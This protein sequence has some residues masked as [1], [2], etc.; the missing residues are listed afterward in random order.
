TKVDPVKKSGAVA[1]LFLAPSLLPKQRKVLPKPVKCNY[2]EEVLGLRGILVTS[3]NVSAHPCRHHGGSV[4]H[5]RRTEL[6]ESRKRFWE[7]VGIC[8]ALDWRGG[9]C[10]DDGRMRR[11][12]WRW[13]RGCR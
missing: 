2:H 4:G 10:R 3:A 5:Q 13:R 7:P 1:P 9:S 8:P 6:H 12:R 11:R